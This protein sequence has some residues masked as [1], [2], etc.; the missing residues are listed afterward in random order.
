MVPTKSVVAPTERTPAAPPDLRLSGFISKL[1]DFQRELFDNFWSYFLQNKKWI[2]T[3]LVH[4]KIG[5]QKVRDALRSLSGDIVRELEN[6]PNDTYELSLIGVLMT[7]AG[8]DYRRL[9]IHYLEFLRE[10]F[11]SHPE[12][13]DF[14]NYEIQ[15][16]LSLSN[17]ETALLGKLIQ[18]GHS[19]GSSS[20]SD[21]H[22]SIR[23]PKEIEYLP[24]GV[25]LDAQLD[26]WLFRNF[27]Q[28]AVFAEDARQQWNQQSAQSL[29]A[30]Q[31]PT[32]SQTPQS[33]IAPIDALKR[34]YQVFVSS[35]YEDLKDE[36]QH[37]IQALLETKCIPL[38]MELF[39]AASIGQWKLIQRII[40]EC[41]YYIVIIAG[42]YGSLSET[43][44]GYTEMEFDYAVAA[45]KPVIGFYHS[46]V[47]TLPLSKSE[48]TD[49]GR[50]RLRR[51]ADKVKKRLCR[52]WSSAAELGSAVKSAIIHELEFNPKPGW[53]RA[54]AMIPSE[55]TEKLKQRIA[56]LEE[57]L[58]RKPAQK[59][60]E[61]KETGATLE[62]QVIFK[63][64]QDQGILDVAVKFTWD[65]L[66]VVVSDLFLYGAW[67][68]DARGSFNHAVESKVITVAAK[69]FGKQAEFTVMGIS[70]EHY[71]GVIHKFVSEKYFKIGRDGWT[72][73]GA[74]LT[75]SEKGLVHLSKVKSAI[76]LN[77]I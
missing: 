10:Q 32:A 60:V 62:F 22:W 77:K 58:K 27:Q 37:V 17:E 3:R 45:G 44:L 72:K 42:R 68:N 61:P 26:E 5:T 46:S 28:R 24:P 30:V 19:F 75:L 65:E 63:K 67:S 55:Q 33:P 14:S 4:S 20:W 31:L 29:D 71:E 57:R 53:V 1:T 64:D 39:P 2:P 48:K 8:E 15:K 35:T 16:A 40:D 9:L 56:D 76:S 34:R 54:D 13:I 38:G 41:D 25:P 51:F 49:A 12:K 6:Q 43:Q 73:Y 11:T 36:R 50:E 74:H 7:S 59:V 66:F 52:P 69:E 18:L 21:N 23:V 47:E 70:D